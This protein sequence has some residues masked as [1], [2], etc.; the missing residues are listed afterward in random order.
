MRKKYESISRK[1]DSALLSKKLRDCSILYVSS[2]FMYSY[3]VIMQFLTQH[4]TVFE[5][6]SCSI[7]IGFPIK[8]GSSLWCNCTARKF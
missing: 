2:P 7:V 5:I 6:N 3:A 8:R 1:K 4:W